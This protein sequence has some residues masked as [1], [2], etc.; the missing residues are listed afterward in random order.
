MESTHFR[1]DH[2]EVIPRRAYGY[3]ASEGGDFR[4]VHDGL[5]A[6]GSSSLFSTV[7]DLARWTI[8][9]DE[10]RPEDRAA[11]ARMH[12]RG[13][14]NDG[15]RTAYGYGVV[16]ATYRGLRN[17]VH[18]GSW[19]G[20]RS[21]VL[22]VPEHRFAVVVLSNAASCDAGRL[23][24]KATD[25]YLA[26]HLAPRDAPEA[27]AAEEAEE[28]PREVLDEYTGTYRPGRAWLVTITREDDQLFAQATA[29][30]RFPMTARTRTVFDVPAYGASI[31]FRRDEAGAV[32]GLRY[33][34]IEAPRVEPV[35]P[36]EA[37]LADLAG[38]YES[39]ELNT[40]LSIAVRDGVIVAHH[41]RHG[42]VVL[43]AAE[44]DEVRTTAWWMQIVVFTRD[45]EG[46]PRELLVSGGRVR[47]LR[48]RRR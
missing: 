15:E 9:L 44:V 21:V 43:H 26:A 39:A 16:V 3:E 46:R 25:L 27:H 42:E 47:N 35:A 45:A 18:S 41:P 48:F 7:R 8:S 10:P 19:A 37:Q 5:L 6:Q 32:T 22:R 23:A 33:R 13:T 30:S 34:G 11:I 20:F 24:R 38:V 14:L 2:Q 31:A 28:I 29:E 40:S 36:T 12:E 4:A 17:V 1:T